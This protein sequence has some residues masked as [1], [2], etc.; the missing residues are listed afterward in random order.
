MPDSSVIVVGAGPVG[1]LTA[2][3]LARAGVD[4]TILERGPDVVDS[5]RAAVYHWCVLE[6]LD[7]LGIREDVEAAGIRVTGNDFRHPASGGVVRI[8]QKA[9]RG[10]VPFPYNV[11]LGQDGLG[12]VAVAHLARLPSARILWNA[13]VEAV[14]SD[15][16][17]ARVRLADGTTLAAD[18]LIGADGGTSLVRKSVDPEFPGFTWDER[19]VA[20]NIRFDFEAHGFNR[21]NMIMD[22]ALGCIVAKLDDRGLW[23]VTFSEDDSLPVETIPER[24][25][26]FM[27]AFLPGDKRYELVQYSPYRM[28][29]RSAPAYRSGRILLAGD[30]AHLTNPTGAMGLTTGL[31]DVELLLDRLLAVL[32]GREGEEA[33]DDYSTRRRTAFLEHASRAA[34]RFKRLVYDGDQAA[35]DAAFEE[36]KVIA[37]D[38][39]AS[40]EFFLGIEFVREPEYRSGL[41][42]IDASS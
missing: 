3:G 12:R 10:A 21:A 36:Y 27:R 2:L 16:R 32:E 7:K 35:I 34:T 19:F 41:R 23:R 37:E 11:N 26:D 8:D 25:D 24:V 5:P 18:W 13:T 40:R 28:H 33:L 14:E 31:F 29:Q 9:L 15:D 6:V 30:A 1:L 38:P 17:E 39:V 42:A 4:V 22:G 20:T